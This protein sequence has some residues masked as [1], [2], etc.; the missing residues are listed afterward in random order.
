MAD[1]KKKGQEEQTLEEMFARLDE[2]IEAM[3]SRELSLEDS[4]RFYQDGMKLVEVCS[5]K[6]E[7]VETKVLLIKEDGELDEF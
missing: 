6:L 7:Q 2:L 1:K 5:K 4:F 3:E